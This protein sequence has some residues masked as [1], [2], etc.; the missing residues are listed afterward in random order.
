[1]K[2][3]RN[4]KCFLSNVHIQR[5]YLT[6]ILEPALTRECQSH[7]LPETYASPSPNHPEEDGPSKSDLEN[8]DV[9]ADPEKKIQGS[10]DHTRSL[11]YTMWNLSVVHE[12]NALR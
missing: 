9:D 7:C 5:T 2:A 12:S 10:L 11:E 8:K 4:T 1:M 6:S 3:Q